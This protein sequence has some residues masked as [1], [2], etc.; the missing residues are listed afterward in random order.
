M[1]ILGGGGSADPHIQPSQARD[2]VLT[3]IGQI[4]KKILGENLE[5]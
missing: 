5:K 2:D 1:E 4:Y 3:K